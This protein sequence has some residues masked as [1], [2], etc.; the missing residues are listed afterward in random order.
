MVRWDNYWTLTTCCTSYI[1]WKKAE[2]HHKKPMDEILHGGLLFSNPTDEDLAIL[3]SGADQ[4]Q[5]KLARNAIFEHANYIKFTSLTP[6]GQYIR[7]ILLHTGEARLVSAEGDPEWGILYTALAA[8][9]REHSW[10]SNFAGEALER[11][12]DRILAEQGSLTLLNPCGRPT[13]VDDV[14][15]EVTIA[16]FFCQPGMTTA[17]AY[18]Q[19]NTFEPID[20]Y[21][22]LSTALA[23]STTKNV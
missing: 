8:V 15:H 12:R 13:A 20:V 21:G 16:G 6:F 19:L 11:V 3:S 22:P 14:E 23:V 10:G 2:W 4:Q 1:L 18:E 9:G 5:W 17:W 7:D